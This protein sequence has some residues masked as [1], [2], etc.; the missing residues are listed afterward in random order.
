MNDQELGDF[1][2]VCR[3]LNEP[4]R[5]LGCTKDEFYPAAIFM[6][7]GL[8]FSYL[9][10]GLVFVFSWV[11]GLKMLKKRYGQAFILVWVYWFFPDAIAKRFLK[12]TPSSEYKFWLN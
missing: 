4:K 8:I 9:F 10:F 12:T 5:I 7:L 1:Y 11:F 6:L 3:Y 2:H